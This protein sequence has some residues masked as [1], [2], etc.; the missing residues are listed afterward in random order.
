MSLGVDYL[1]SGKSSKTSYISL[2]L[3]K[4]LTDSLEWKQTKPC[5]RQDR[6]SREVA[7]FKD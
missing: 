3:I 4:I 5:S 1:L 2:S 6:G 7:Y